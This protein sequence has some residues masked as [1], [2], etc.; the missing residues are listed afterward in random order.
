MLAR[1]QSSENLWKIAKTFAEAYKISWGS[2][3]GTI[4]FTLF[5]GCYGRKELRKKTHT[6]TK[7]T[8]G[9]EPVTFQANIM[10]FHTCL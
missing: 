1:S 3:E 8:N 10:Q 6:Q 4:Q 2:N 7:S 5:S 9:V